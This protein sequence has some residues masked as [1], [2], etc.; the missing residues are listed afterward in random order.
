MF[1]TFNRNKRSMVL[2]LKN[3]KGKEVF[4]FSLKTADIVVDNTPRGHG[5]LRAGIRT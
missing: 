4:F 3:P 1:L 5:K 2:D